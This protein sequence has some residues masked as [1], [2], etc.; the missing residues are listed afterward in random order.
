MGHLLGESM[1][2]IGKK[3]AYYYFLTLQKLMDPTLGRI[4]TL[5]THFPDIYNCEVWNSSFFWV[6]VKL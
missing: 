4:K 1:A 2:H 5:S 6:N 3:K